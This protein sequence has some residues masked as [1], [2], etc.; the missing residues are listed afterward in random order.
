MDMEIT[1]KGFSDSLLDCV[2][3]TYCQGKQITFDGHMHR[4]NNLGVQLEATMLYAVTQLR[5]KLF[6]V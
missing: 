5:N 4:K 3:Y 2:K 1:Y 6:C